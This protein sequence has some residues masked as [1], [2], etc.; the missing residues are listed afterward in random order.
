MKLAE[1]TGVGRLVLLQE[2][3]HFLDSLG[4]QLLANGD[5]VLALILPEVNLGD[6]VG[7]F[8]VFKGAFWVSFEDLLDLLGPVNDGTLE[9]LSFILAGGFFT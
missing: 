6:W 5:E 8:A 7:V 4:S 3:E 9:E 2:F 1:G